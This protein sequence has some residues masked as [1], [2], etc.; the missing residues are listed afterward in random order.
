MWNDSPH[1]HPTII[2]FLSHP[3]VIHD[4]ELKST[5]LA[6]LSGHED[7]IEQGRG[8][9][10]GLLFA[11][12][13]DAVHHDFP[14]RNYTREQIIRSKSMRRILSG[15]DGA[16]AL[17]ADGVEG[18]QDFFKMDLLLSGHAGILSWSAAN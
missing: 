7:G 14:A 3:H 16:S 17:R 6:S 15:R 8:P 9:D 1:N 10:A 12:Q 13:A 5:L 4:Q 11:V 18:C 2:L